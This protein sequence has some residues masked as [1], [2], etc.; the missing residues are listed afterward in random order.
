MMYIRNKYMQKTRK[1]YYILE[2][3]VKKKGNYRTI[4]VRYLGTA[5]KLLADLKELDKF[6]RKKP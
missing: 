4:N 1:R 6:R 5:N 3:R 2:E